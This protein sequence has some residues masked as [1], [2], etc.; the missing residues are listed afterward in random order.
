[1]DPRFYTLKLPGNPV[2]QVLSLLAAGVV[3]IAAVVLGAVLLTFVFGVAVV[4]GAVLV[5][6][7]WWLRRKLQRSGGRRDGG[8]PQVIEVEYS[9]VDEREPDHRRD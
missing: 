7:L 2:L 3:M 9:V 1:M 6:R 5:V 8:S 4:V